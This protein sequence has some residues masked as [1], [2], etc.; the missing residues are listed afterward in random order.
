M[1]KVAFVTGTSSGIGLATVDLFASNGWCVAATVR[2]TQDAEVFAGRGNIRPFIMDVRDQSSIEDATLKAH[3]AFGGISVLINNAGYFQMGPLEC[4]TMGQIRDQFE[5]NLFGLVSVTKAVL[6][7][8]RSAKCGTIINVS[9]IA[10]DVG[11]PFASAYSAS[12]AAIIALTESLNIELDGLG[13]M[14]K[15]II[16]GMHATKIFTKLDPAELGLPREYEPLLENFLAIQTASKGGLPSSVANAIWA[17][18]NDETGSTV[19][20]Y[21]GSDATLIPSMKRLLGE[22]RYFKMFR[23]TILQGNARIINALRR[24]GVNVEF[25]PK[26]HLNRSKREVQT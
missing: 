1:A 4:S 22:R 23:T 3:E 7:K 2:K 17:A 26:I 11:Y 9:S 5:T 8:M 6:P 15:V 13:I 20:Y 16:P 12:K 24:G 19:R 18:A 25:S 14:A 21:V 10:G